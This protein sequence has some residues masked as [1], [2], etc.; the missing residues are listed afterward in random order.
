MGVNITVSKLCFLVRPTL[1]LLALAVPIGAGEPS[2]PAAEAATTPAAPATPAAPLPKP[3]DV[4]ARFVQVIGGKQAFDKIQSQHIKGKFDMGGQG[5]T[6]DLEV[7]AKRP[8]KLVI[9]INLPGIGDLWQGFDGTVGWS[10]NPAT[11]PMVLEGKMLDQVR[12]Q[13]RFD[14]VL[15]E[16]SDF[17]SMETLG[18]EPFE[19]KTCYKLK[20]VRKSGQEVTEYY[21]VQSGLLVGSSEVQETPLGAIAAT[22]LTSD[23]KKF[24]DVL[25]ATK[26]TQKM[27][28]LAQVMTFT[29][30]D[31]N[32]VDD[33]AFDL[34]DQIKGLA[35]K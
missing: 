23:Y 2:K 30:M 10:L 22:G 13:A 35:K 27:G 4:I 33:S 16:A 9:K 19:G 3:E 5:I 7:F 25:F 15:H 8:D 26:L 21:D 20:L 6:G 34:P 24:G 18:R 12:E 31:F 17:K 14:G 28:P 29:S 32:K 11:G 1:L